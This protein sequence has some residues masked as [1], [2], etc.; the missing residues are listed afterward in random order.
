[1]FY[2]CSS[3]NN[4]NVTNFDTQNVTDMSEMFDGCKFIYDEKNFK[5]EI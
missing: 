4:L 5:L 3:L 2:N 1:M